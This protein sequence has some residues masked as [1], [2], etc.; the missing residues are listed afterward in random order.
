M[1]NLRSRFDERR[2]VC[3]WRRVGFLRMVAR[4]LSLSFVV[5][6]LLVPSAGA[7]TFSNP[8]P[9]MIPSAGTSGVAN[10]YPS[11][12]VVT[13]LPG[14]V[15][16]ARVTFVGLNYPGFPRDI[17]TLLVGPNGLKSIVMSD[18]CGENTTPFSN[19]TLTWDDAGADPPAM[20]AGPCPSGSV[21][22][23]TDFQPAANDPF[24]AP[25]PAGPYPVAL[26]TFNAGPANGTWSL[27]AV[28]DFAPDAGSMASW[29]LELLPS[30]QCAGQTAT[31]AANVGTAGD[32]DLQGTPGP[33]VMLGL[34]G[35]DTINGLGGND[36]ICGGAGKDKIQGGPGKDKLLGEGGKDKLRGQG[37][38]DVCKG[39]P[40]TD[41]AS[42]CEKEKSI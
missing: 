13:G 23:P 10:P 34:E 33:D 31:V 26:S 6:A 38:K 19:V 28:D 36:V 5:F 32:E 8:A 39:G 1:R 16:K 11:N 35:A 27:Y 17:D 2:L 22:K 21:Y 3:P 40:K 30:A 7:S 41:T 4:I 24:V 37:G 15:V 18:L 42:G 9:I 20:G 29:R 12:I 25:A 14:N